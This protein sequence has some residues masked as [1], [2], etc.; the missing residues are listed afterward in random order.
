[1]CVYMYETS[2]WLA[3]SKGSDVANETQ[4]YL[5][6]SPSGGSCRAKW[7]QGPEWSTLEGQQSQSVKLRKFQF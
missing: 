7:Q 1:M 6:K 2:M 3:S 4:W 5:Y